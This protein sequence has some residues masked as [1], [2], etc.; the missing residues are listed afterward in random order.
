MVA[1]S[2][3]PGR[4]ILN[5]FF[6]LAYHSHNTKRAR[7]PLATANINACFQATDIPECFAVE[8]PNFAYA[9]SAI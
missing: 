9:T 5:F 1:D 3:R 7:V 4:W 2:F 6:F 8:T